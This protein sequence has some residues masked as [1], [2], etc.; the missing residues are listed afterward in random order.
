LLRKTIMKSKQRLA[1]FSVPLMGA[2]LLI[3]LISSANATSMYMDLAAWQAAAGSNVTETTSY[4][5]DFDAVTSFDLIGGPTVTG[6]PLSPIFATPLS[7]WGAWCCGYTG[8]VL[9]RFGN[10]T[11]T[12]TLSG[13]VSGLG[14]FIEPGTFAPLN[15]T[16]TLSD[17]SS[18][19]EEVDGNGP[20]QFFGWTG[21]G[22]TSFQVSVD[23]PTDPPGGFAIGD[24]FVATVAP[25]PGPIV[26][27]GLPALVAVASGGLLSWWRR[28]RSARAAANLATN[29]T[30]EPG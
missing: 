29:V 27:S 14:M 7:G 30:L 18:L 22:V 16:L 2:M 15:I 19:M 25:V 10:N 23:D 6:D 26:G 5:T 21:P 17:G 24:I 4:G 1:L 12:F 3:G 9:A 11:Y 8:Q 28:K 13:P 20:A